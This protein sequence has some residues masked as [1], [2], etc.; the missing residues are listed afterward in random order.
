MKSKIQTNSVPAI[1]PIPQLD[2]QEVSQTIDHSTLTDQSNGPQQQPLWT[3]PNNDRGNAD[4]L[5]D[6]CGNSFRFCPGIG[7]LIWN[8]YRWQQDAGKMVHCWASH[9]TR[10]ANEEVRHSTDFNV[11][12]KRALAIG[13]S[14]RIDALLRIAE[15]DHRIVI[16]PAT[17]DSNPMYVSALNGIFDLETG[18]FLGPRQ[19]YLSLLHLGCQFDE[20]ATCPRWETFLLEIMG[21]DTEMVRFL[22]RLV[23]YTLTGYTSEQ[24]LVFLVGNGSNGKSVFLE[25]IRQLLGSYST[26]ASSELLV[27]AGGH[28]S[29]K[30]ELAGLPGKRLLLAPEVERCVRLNEAL[31]KDLTGS[32]SIRA[33][34]K[35][36][37]GFDF[38]PVV[39]I[40]MA[41]NHYPRVQGTDNGIWRRLKVVE[42]PV[43][44]A[45]DKRDPYLLERL[46]QELPGILNW[47]I[48][49]CQEWRKTR[50]QIPSKVLTKT[51]SYRIDQDLLSDFIRD[52]LDTNQSGN[53][54][55]SQVYEVYKMWAAAKG[56]R[57][58]I[59]SK[60]LSRDLKE[61][62]MTDAD[63]DYWRNVQLRPAIHD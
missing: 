30:N 56:L 11:A 60:Q 26:R 34:A 16:D 48:F 19:D 58:Q 17:L 46:R 2:G 62:G 28:Q 40:W 57:H 54:R 37:A 3:Y 59:S 21:G 61:H 35:Y 7:W 38:K 55:K 12:A 9:L 4:F 15:S 36:Q 14:R 44:F 1:H 53:I 22:Q 25:V 50:L 8:G 63:S 39:K 6:R 20:S 13:D 24:I 51:N 42:F 23:G 47:A 43:T 5:I 31:V 33:E 27:S 52:R 45:P 49:G 41:G 29:N 18:G 32:E 10:I